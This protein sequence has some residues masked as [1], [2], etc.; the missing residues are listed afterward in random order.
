M[1][2]YRPRRIRVAS[3]RRVERDERHAR[4]RHPPPGARW[5]RATPAP[6][7]GAP[8]PPPP[9]PPRLPARPRSSTSRK[10]A[11]VDSPTPPSCLERARV[12]PPASA[13][14]GV[15]PYA[16]TTPPPARR[17]GNTPRPS[18]RTAAAARS[19]RASPNASAA[20]PAAESGGR[21]PVACNAIP[22][23]LVAPRR[24]DP[25]RVF[26]APTPRGGANVLAQVVRATFHELRD[27]S[28]GENLEESTTRLR[29]LSPRP[30]ARRPRATPKSPTTRRVRPRC[31]AAAAAA[32]AAPARAASREE[33]AASSPR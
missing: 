12:G 9:R 1:L 20:A 3:R 4:A 32:F 2:R 16:K 14:P 33:D 22:A 18:L 29:S 28:T 25:T 7:R 11:A 10:H 5:K 30:D 19:A 15:S 17:R 27:G 8:P 6:R 21:A 24:L 31:T 23:P 26:V 13:R